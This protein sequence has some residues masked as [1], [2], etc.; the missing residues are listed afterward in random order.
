MDLEG[1]MLSEIS[2]RKAN[3]VQLIYRWNKKKKNSRHQTHRKRGQT[4]GYHGHRVEGGKNR[5]SWSKHT[6][7]RL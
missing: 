1:I 2:Q 6:K 5:G 7:L 4:C 3:T